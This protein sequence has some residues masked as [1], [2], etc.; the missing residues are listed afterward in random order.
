LRA[1]RGNLDQTSNA[2]LNAQTLKPLDCHALQ[3][4]NDGINQHFM[5]IFSSLLDVRY[6]KPW[7]NDE[8]PDEYKPEWC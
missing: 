8:N 7:L 1:K 2:K 4:R 3:A 5:A 6:R